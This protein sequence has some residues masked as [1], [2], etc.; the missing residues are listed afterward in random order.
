MKKELL[1]LCIALAAIEMQSQNAIPNPDFELWTTNSIE[2]PMHYPFTSNDNCYKQGNPSN[3]KK[4]TPGFHGQYALELKTLTQNLA[5]IVNTDSKQGNMNLWTNGMAYSGRPTGIRGYYKYNVATA[6]SALVIVMFRKNKTTIG[7]YKYKIGGIKNDFT[8]FNFTFSTPLSQD[9]DSLIFALSSS[10]YYK[11]MNGVVGST[12][13][14]DSISLNG[15]DIQPPQFNGDFEMWDQIQYPPTLNEWNTQNRLSGLD[16]TSDS[17]TGQYAV[18]LTTYLDPKSNPPSA[19]PG[20]LSSG[21]WDNTC[22]CINGGSPY[23]LIKDTLAFWYKY[24]PVAGDAAQ[25]F[26]EFKK[27]GTTCGGNNTIIEPSANYKYKEIPFQLDVTPDHV[28]IQAI[29]SL[30][31]NKALSYVG[32]TLII[33][34]M[35]FKSS[36]INSDIEKYY[37]PEEITLWPNPVQNSLNI[38]NLNETVRLIE[39]YNITGKKVY[40]TTLLAS[41]IDVSTLTKGVYF[42]KIDTAKKLLHFKIIKL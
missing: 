17:K 7:T 5:Y 11:N 19:S 37:A 23:T 26:L 13:T 30:W 28:I 22:N 21:Y 18:K 6:D 14:I 20:Y 40:S 3:I 8:P 32:S 36:I 29:S 41:N 38:S 27:N 4:V 24:A 33:D 1:F 10:D 12:L 25:V 35:Y 9:P 2:N 42:V 34:N 15:I 31:E 16:R 39:L